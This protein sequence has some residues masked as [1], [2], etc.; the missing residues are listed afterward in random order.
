[1]KFLKFLLATVLVTALAACGGGGGS[2]GTTTS[3]N[4]TSGNSATGDQQTTATASIVVNIFSGAGTSTN[5]ISAIEISKVSITL[6]DA[7]GKP[8]PGT[9]VTFSENGSS[10]LSFAPA[11][12]TALTDASGVASVEIRAAFS[13]SVGA[14]TIG[15]TATVSGIAITA[16]KAIAITS[17]PTDGTNAPNP[18]A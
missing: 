1:M 18:Q 10:L 6:K 11:S 4:G 9:V 14:T 8:V 5:S 17:A 2:A 15:A 12:K 3:G 7:A 13:N 16:Q